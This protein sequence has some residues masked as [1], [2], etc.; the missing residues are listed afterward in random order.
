V[1]VVGLHRYALLVV[2]LKIPSADAARGSALRKEKVAHEDAQQPDA[3]RFE[4]VSRSQLRG[5]STPPISGQHALVDRIED[6]QM[7][8]TGDQH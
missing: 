7:R 5:T 2:R 6:L 4:K 1:S 8:R 3:M